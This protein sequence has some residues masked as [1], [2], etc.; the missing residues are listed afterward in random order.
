MPRRYSKNGPMVTPSNV[1]PHRKT[2]QLCEQIK[3]CLSWVIGSAIHDD[4]YLLCQI[5]SVEPLPG[6]GRVLIEIAIPADISVVDA[7]IAL[8][9]AARSLRLEV[10]QW[11]TR[12]KVPEL[13][14]FAVP[15]S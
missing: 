9:G 2:L 12:R 4:R 11:I 8:A 14:L 13:I 15:M 7:N 5:N 10:A 1:R 3:E 6:S